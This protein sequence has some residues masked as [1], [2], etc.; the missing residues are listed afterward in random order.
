[1]TYRR[2]ASRAA[3]VMAKE[4]AL[5]KIW[6]AVTSRLYQGRYAQ[7]WCDPIVEKQHALLVHEFRRQIGDTKSVVK[8]Y[9]AVDEVIHRATDGSLRFVSTRGR[10]RNDD[11]QPN[12][13]APN[14]TPKK[15]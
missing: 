11:H 13:G 7:P 5:G 9:K 3:L 10:P 1:M 4:L 14:G 8:I 15:T 12:T 6:S 2:F